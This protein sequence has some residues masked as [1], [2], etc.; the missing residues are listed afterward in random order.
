M[1]TFVSV[2]GR[3]TI[4]LPPALRKA[5]HLDQP[6]AQ[7]EIVE[8]DG[9]LVLIPKVAVDASVAWFW[10]Q[11]WQEMEAEASR[12]LSAG[13]CVSYASGDDFLADLP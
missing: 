12:Q 11:R 2:Q 10:S 9:R 8:E 3:G 4:A 6:G 5:Y 1:S 13:D 7:V